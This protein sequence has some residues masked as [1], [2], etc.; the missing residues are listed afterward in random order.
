MKEKPKADVH[1]FGGI[2]TNPHE[3][4]TGYYLGHS[5]HGSCFVE[6]FGEEKLKKAGVYH[7][8]VIDP[9]HAIKEEK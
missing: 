8:D 6:H 4:E 7:D 2:Q 9:D 5:W 3:S 1:L